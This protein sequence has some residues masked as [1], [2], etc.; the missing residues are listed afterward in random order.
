MHSFNDSYSD[1]KNAPVQVHLKIGWGKC[2]EMFVLCSIEN[3]PFS[4]DY[5]FHTVCKFKH[6]SC[7]YK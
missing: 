3:I 5:H 7:Y 2:P 1:T 4:S 6:I